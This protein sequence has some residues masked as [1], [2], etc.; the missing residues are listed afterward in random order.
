MQVYEDKV[1]LL[2][3]ARRLCNKIA[4]N[5]PLVVQSAKRVLKFAENHRTE[6]TL[7]HLALWNTAFL[8]SEDLIEA[9][10]SFLQKRKPR[11]ANKL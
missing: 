3:N 5:S 2:E 4:Q 7:E 10:T 11:F 6:E 8:E 1:K 9:F